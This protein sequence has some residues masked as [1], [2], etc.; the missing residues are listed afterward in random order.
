MPEIGVLIA[1][2][3]NSFTNKLHLLLDREGYSVGKARTCREAFDLASQFQPTVALLGRVAPR[4]NPVDTLTQFITYCPSTSIVWLTPPTDTDH[5]LQAINLGISGVFSA[6][7]K[8]EQ[9]LP[10]VRA[11]AQGEC[12]F[13]PDFL[14]RSLSQYVSAASPRYLHEVAFTDFERTILCRMSDG[15][16]DTELAAEAKISCVAIQVHVRHIFCR[17]NVENRLQAVA[18]AIRHRLRC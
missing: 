18:W 6:K 13:D 12:V 5:F 15:L 2:R 1:D 11:A 16:S 17:L 3:R 4:S 7:T 14:K 10:V 9:M 8:P